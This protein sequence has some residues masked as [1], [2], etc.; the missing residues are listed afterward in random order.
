MSEKPAESVPNRKITMT[1]EEKEFL[2]TEY[3][4]LRNEILATLQEWRG[5]ERYAVAAAGAIWTW[6]STHKVHARWAWGIPLVFSLCGYLRHM[7]ILKHLGRLGEYIRAR[8]EPRFGEVGWEG[9]FKRPGTDWSLDAA[10]N[11]AVWIVLTVAS[12][13]APFIAHF[14][15]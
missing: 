6:I 9:Y 12:L 2:L 14:F 8:I 10:S 15:E 11:S 1:P 3:P 7:A 5:T 4:A 13:L